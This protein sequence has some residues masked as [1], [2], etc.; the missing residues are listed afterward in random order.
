MS[1]IRCLSNPEGLYI[2][3]DVSGDAVITGGPDMEPGIPDPELW[4]TMPNELWDKLLE[5]WVIGW[6]ED[7]TVTEVI[8]GVKHEA[9]VT[10]RCQSRNEE[11]GEGGRQAI[12]I[13][14][15]NDEGKS[16]VLDNLWP[17]TMHHIASEFENPYLGAG[18]IKRFLLRLLKVR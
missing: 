17:V 1:Y 15:K 10:E 6:Y 8:G 7:V 9:S 4:R 18:R 12:K 5:A 11:T 2:W 3:G 14:Y 16:W 13:E